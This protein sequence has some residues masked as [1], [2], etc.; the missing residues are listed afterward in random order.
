MIMEATVTASDFRQK[1]PEIVKQ[2]SSGKTLIAISHSKPVFRTV[3]GIPI[4][5]PR[6][7]HQ[8]L[9]EIKE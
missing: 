1:F 4:L 6:Q 8:L 7:A 2:V 9:D 3:H 5:T